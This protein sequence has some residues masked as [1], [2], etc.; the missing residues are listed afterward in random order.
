MRA[1]AVQILDRQ[2]Q[3]DKIV[4]FRAELMDA[5]IPLGVSA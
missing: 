2:R 3:S 5:V 1:K 4:Q